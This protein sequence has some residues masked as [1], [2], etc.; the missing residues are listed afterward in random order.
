[1]EMCEENPNLVK[2][3]RNYRAVYMKI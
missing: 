3:G 2:I 1:M